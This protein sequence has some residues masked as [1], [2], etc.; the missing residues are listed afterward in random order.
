MATSLQQPEFV[1][2]FVTELVARGVSDEKTTMSITTEIAANK[3]TRDRERV[4]KGNS[5][6]EEVMA[7]ILS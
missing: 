7:Q 1:C 3:L 5:F 6:V 2:A 4:E